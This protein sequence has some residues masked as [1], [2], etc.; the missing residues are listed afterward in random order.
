[1][2]LA[3]D[4][5]NSKSDTC[6][7]AKAASKGDSSNDIKKETGLD[8]HCGDRSYSVI[9]EQLSQFIFCGI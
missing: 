5:K 9:D 2:Q 6:R 4:N 8:R 3:S 1:M 7:A